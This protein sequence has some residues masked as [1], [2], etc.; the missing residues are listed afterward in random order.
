MKRAVLMLLGF[1][2][3]LMGA[4]LYYYNHG[5]KIFL[6]PQKGVATR[7]VGESERFCTDRG[8]EVTIAKRL[9]V[10]WKKGADIDALLKRYGLKRIK[11]MGIG[12]LYLLEADSVEGAIE[13]ADRLYES[14]EVIFA[15]PDVAKRRRLR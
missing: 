12:D 7:S 11:K 4:D 14:S 13:A 15:Q 5:K 10:K 1:A 9:V 6:R 2:A 3:T 8:E